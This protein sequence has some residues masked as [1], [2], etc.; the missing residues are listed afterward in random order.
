MNATKNATVTTTYPDGE[1]ETVE[2][3]PDDYVIVLGPKR[4]ISNIQNYPA[5]G[6][7]VLTIKTETVDGTTNGAE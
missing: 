2:V 7:V 6:T 4:W 1:T 5:K 3:P